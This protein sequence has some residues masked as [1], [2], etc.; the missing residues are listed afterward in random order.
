MTKQ[1]YKKKLILAEKKI[2]AFCAFLTIFYAL[3]SLLRSNPFKKTGQYLTPKIYQ[4]F[5]GQKN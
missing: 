1:R 2:E 4:Y 5:S 3:F